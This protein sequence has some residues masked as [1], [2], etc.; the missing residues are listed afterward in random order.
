MEARVRASALT[1]LTLVEASDA[2]RNGKVSSVALV[3]AA[4]EAFKARNPTIK[5]SINL[6]P[7]DALEAAEGLD[8]LGK[9]GRMLGSLHGV[10]LAHKD[11]YYRAG[12]PCTCGSRIR[13]AVRPTYTA[14]EVKRLEDAG[15]ITIGSLN[16]AE[17]A[18]NP[19]GHNAH[20]GD[21][22]N[23]WNVDHC[24]GGSSS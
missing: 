19:T 14:T 17:F 9:A 6:D 22:H 20:F 7:Q 5:A 23:P 24:T 2:V 15:S 13:R 1:H 4:L 12:K 11:M 10:P 16:M 21:C 3:E 8:R 18:Q